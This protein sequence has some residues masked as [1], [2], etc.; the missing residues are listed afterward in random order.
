MNFFVEA[1]QFL[2]TLGL[3]PPFVIFLVFREIYF[4]IVGENPIDPIV[5]EK[6]PIEEMWMKIKR[7]FKICSLWTLSALVIDP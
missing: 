3:L 5:W 1:F 4:R 6:D 7:Y 2:T